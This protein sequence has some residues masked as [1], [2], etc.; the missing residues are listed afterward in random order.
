MGIK[1][2]SIQN[3]RAILAPAMQQSIQV[4][5]LP[6]LDLCMAIEQE[7][8]TNPILEADAQQA[9]P[10]EDQQMRIQLN[11]LT[12]NETNTAASFND[13]DSDSTIPMV[14]SIS[15]TEHLLQQ[16]HLEITD[17]QLYAIG[18][19]IIGNLDDKGYLTLPVEEIAEALGV[20]DLGLIHKTLS[21]VQQFEPL[22][23]AARNIQECLFIQIASSTHPLANT[24]ITVIES[25]YDDFLHQRFDTIAK[26]MDLS[27]ETIKSTIKF[28]ASFDPNPAQHFQSNEQ[29]IYIQPDASV[30]RTAEGA[31][32]VY[33]NKR[34]VPQLTV[35]PFYQ[36]LL[37]KENINPAEKEFIKEKLERAITFIKSVQQ[38]S[39]TLERLVN[40]IVLKQQAF[41]NDP[42]NLS[43]TPMNYKE[44]ALALQRCESTISRTVSHKYVDTPVGLFPLK[45][46]FTQGVCNKDN[47]HVSSFDI[48]EE[49][50][51]LID[52]ENTS[53][54]LSDNQIQDCLKQRGFPLARRTISKYRQTLKIAPSHQR[55]ILN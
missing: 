21:L 28:I 1:I 7:I 11:N 27:I 5:L 47:A 30:I 34:G 43:L 51:S 52:Q 19:Y 44:V 31:Y 37:Q 15:I 54:P 10:L 45:F 9:S 39:E 23:I 36:H 4:L 20:T 6:Y 55:K 53:D 35:N 24:A 18:E 40:Y 2:L 12:Y 14:K 25:Y 41:F 49:I 42:E 32:K 29:N 8:Q 46:F 16:L 48:K 50:K 22:G 3:Q 26:N 38:R 33:I 13:E 17:P